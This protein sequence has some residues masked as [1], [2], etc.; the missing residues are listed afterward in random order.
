MR[1][2]ELE[3]M[4]K[5]RLTRDDVLA[6]LPDLVGQDL[7]GVDL[8]G[9]DLRGAKL[10]DADLSDADLHGAGLAE[11]DL[12]W[13]RLNRVDFR[14]ANLQGANLRGCDMFEADFS[15]ANLVGAKLVEP[16]R[17]WASLTNTNLSGAVFSGATYN[18]AGEPH[19]ILPEGFDPETYGMVLVDAA[20]QPITAA[21]PKPASKPATLPPPEDSPE[22]TIDDVVSLHE[23]GETPG[24]RRL[25]S[26]DL[27]GMTLT[28][29]DFRQAD[30]SGASFKGSRL[31]G[32]NL[33]H[34]ILREADLSG[35]T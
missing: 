12:R 21:S 7:Q 18:L 14:G 26:I 33:T 6:R 23:L 3:A 10:R 34:A 15:D 5:A 29:A 22:L 32:A 20:G 11:A 8:S 28:R 27:G 2:E 9:L 30:L 4:P 35:P 31:Q 24:R 17:G 25:R 13:A 19:T 16:D 1:V